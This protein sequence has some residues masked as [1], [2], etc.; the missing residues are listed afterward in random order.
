MLL[1]RGTGWLRRA[2]VGRV[3]AFAFVPMVILFA[4]AGT[5]VSVTQNIS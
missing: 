2:D 5:C 4:L 3:I 1:A